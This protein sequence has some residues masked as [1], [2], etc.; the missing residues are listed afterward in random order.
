MNIS[1]NCIELV[2]HFEGCSLDAYKCPAGVLTIGYG[3]TGKSLRGWHKITQEEAEIILQ[4]DL[5]GFEEAVTK[6]VTVP[7]TQGQFDAL[8]SFAFNC[9]AKALKNST[10]LKKLNARDYNGASNEFLRWNK[11]GG[12]VLAGLTRRRRAEQ[13][14]FKTGQLI[15]TKGQIK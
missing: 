12:K 8:V 14:L 3:H 11:A 7:L 2:K 6:M 5:E 15:F 1:E 13:H 9:G 4:S 10:L